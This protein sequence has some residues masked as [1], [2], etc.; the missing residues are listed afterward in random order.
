[1]RHGETAEHDEQ[2][3]VRA[4]PA[5]HQHRRQAGGQHRRQKF[6]GVARVDQFEPVEGA[7][8]RR[9]EGRRDRRRGAGRYHGALVLSAQVEILADRGEDPGPE[10][11]VSRFHA[12]RGAT[13][14]GDDGK[15]GQARR[16]AKTELATIQ[17]IR[18]DRVD[19]LGGAK[20]LQGQRHKAK[21]QPANRG[22]QRQPPVI[23]GGLLRKMLAKN[24]TEVE[25]LQRQDKVAQP[26]RYKADETAHHRRQ[27]DLRRFSVAHHAPQFGL[28]QPRRAKD[29]VQSAGSGKLGLRHNCLTG[30]KKIRLPRPPA[31]PHG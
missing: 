18:L 24:Q 17:G 29:A 16:I 23:N 14:V 30:E 12:H 10:L 25:R 3:R 28:T 5:G 15:A 22:N 7:G 20:L 6:R 19:D 2:R 13:S 4:Q 8:Q 31:A 21:E 9:V 27:D 1:M 26:D 11:A